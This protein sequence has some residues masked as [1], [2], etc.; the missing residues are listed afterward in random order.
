[1]A[2]APIL[3]LGLATSASAVGRT[4]PDMAR[5]AADAGA[6]PSNAMRLTA[7][8]SIEGPVRLE[9]KSAPNPIWTV[10]LTSTFALAAALL[11]ALVG[12]WS[13]Q[14]SS[15]AAIIQKT[16]ELEIESLDRRLA[17]FVGPFLQLSEENRTLAEEMK[18]KYG[19]AKLRTLTAMLTPGWR[20]TLSKGDAHLLEVVVG[21]GVDLRKL[22]M[23]KG[24]AAV[25]PELIPYFSKASSHFRFLEL[26]YRGSLDMD[27]SKYEAY[28]YPRELDDIMRLESARLLARREKL[29][30]E[31]YAPHDRMPDLD[32]SSLA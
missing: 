20:E 29:R 13:T 30:S 5:G 19:G 27:P 12:F 10:A 32:L 23:E 6:E 3:L 28:V 11:G 15:R 7:K 22:L 21:N 26:A 16:N 14:R 8:V 25:S 1:M 31:P 18:R 2:I 17:E 9:G 4:V 24:A